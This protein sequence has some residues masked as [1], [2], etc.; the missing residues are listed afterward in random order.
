MSVFFESVL[1]LLSA[2]VMKC[3]AQLL[4]P[5]IPLFPQNTVEVLLATDKWHLSLSVKTEDRKVLLHK[6]TWL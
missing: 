6:V 5:M 4:K 2:P 3:V 1:L